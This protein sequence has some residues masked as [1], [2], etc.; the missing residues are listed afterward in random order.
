MMEARRNPNLILLTVS[1]LAGR[2]DIGLIAVAVW[3]VVAAL[4]LL[5]RLAT[6]GYERATTGPLAPWLQSVGTASADDSL[7]VRV[8]VRS[9][10]PGAD[11]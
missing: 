8:F 4:I 3:T 2:P 6:A 7:A 11:A 1:L 5:V 10:E 9:L